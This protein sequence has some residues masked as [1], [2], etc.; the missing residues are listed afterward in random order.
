MNSQ[1]A[2]TPCDDN[3]RM[4]APVADGAQLAVNRAMMRSIAPLLA[5]LALLMVA[6]ALQFALL[7]V[8][9]DSEGFADWVIAVMSA[10]YFG[11]FLVGGRLAPRWIGSVGHVRTFAAMA[12]LASV[13]ILVQAFSVE[14]ATWLISRAWSGICIAAMV[15][16]VEAWLSGSSEPNRR[17]S[18]LAIYMVVMH[19]AFSAG[20][21]LVGAADPGGFAL[22]AVVS[23]LLSLSL[24]PVLLGGADSQLIHLRSGLSVA[25]LAR[26]APVGVAA[27]FSGGLAWGVIASML[28]TLGLREGFDAGQAASIGMAGTAGAILSQLPVGRLSDAVDRRLVILGTAVL[29][30]VVGLVG[31][32]LVTSGRLWVLW[33][34][35]A[36]IGAASLPSYSLAIAQVGDVLAPDET[37]AAAGTLVTVS[38]L[39]SA[40]GPLVA[41]TAI[42]VIGSPGVPFVFAI[43]G[44]SLA[45]FAAWQL[46]KS[47]MIEP[48]G[49]YVPLGA[50]TTPVGTAVLADEIVGESEA[51]TTDA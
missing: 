9:A 40:A 49:H 35:A 47:A 1:S 14:P 4:L 33:L 31:M 32:G 28:I 39:G 38:S 20:Q 48:H 7:A 41:M 50:R 15:T 21:L 36:A 26:R 3:E 44:G 27:S 5:G 8:R 19:V 43:S 17:G 30:S 29:T 46:H 24:V 37:V 18:T 13:A 16:S 12:S 10:C 42:A 11:G 6:S 22:F 51:I 2:A 34:L 23:I 25:A 45:G